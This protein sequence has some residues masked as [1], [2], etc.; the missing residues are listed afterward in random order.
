MTTL[1]PSAP[2]PSATA[3]RT[4]FRH[5]AAAPRRWTALRWIALAL[6]ATFALILLT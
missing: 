2:E 5:T 4:V 3:G 6:L 1:T